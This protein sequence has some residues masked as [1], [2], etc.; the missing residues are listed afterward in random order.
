VQFWQFVSHAARG[1]LGQSIRTGESVRTMIINALPVTIELSVLA[2]LV[3]AAV[4]ML[5]DCGHT[6][7][8]ADIESTLVGRDIVE[9][10]WSF[11]IVER[12]DRGYWDVFRAVE[13][14]ARRLLGAAEPHLFEAEMKDQEQST[15]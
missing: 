9:G 4:S 3:A 11:Q 5:A 14:H 12:Y 1:D 8:D 13:S 10:M 2:I 7:L 15:D 6:E